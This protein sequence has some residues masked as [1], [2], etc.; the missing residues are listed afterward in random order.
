MIP[1]IGHAQIDTITGRYNLITTTPAVRQA[2]DA[3]GHYD[4]ESIMARNRRRATVS[5]LGI[6]RETLT[7]DELLRLM[8]W[9]GVKIG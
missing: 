1:G 6:S 9:M 2:L 3:I 4:A 5:T 7:E 8:E